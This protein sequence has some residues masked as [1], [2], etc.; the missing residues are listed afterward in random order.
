MTMR[1][2]CPILSA[3]LGKTNWMNWV[4]FL[5][6]S[7]LIMALSYSLLVLY[8]LSKSC[9]SLYSSSSRPRQINSKRVLRLSGEGAVTNILLKPS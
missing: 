6:I 8:T 5:N 2:E 1:S 7:T 9:L 4:W 3:S